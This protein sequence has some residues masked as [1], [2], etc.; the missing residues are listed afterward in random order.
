[1]LR[2]VHFIILLLLLVVTQSF[3]QEVT[4]VCNGEGTSKD[5]AVNNALRSAVEQTF[6][7]FVSSNTE[8]VNDELIRDEIV[9]I[10]RGNIKNF[11]EISY[12]D[13]GEQK[14][15]TLE[16]TVSVGQLVSYTKNK[17]MA[18]ELAGATF[19]TNFKLRKLYLENG[20]KAMPH[21]LNDLVSYAEKMY[22]F[23]IHTKEPI[24]RNDDVLVDITI[25][26]TLNKN[27][28]EFYKIYKET[29][30]KIENS[31]RSVRIDGS[32]GNDQ[33]WKIIKSYKDIMERLPR[34]A[35]H[36][37]DV[38]DNLNDTVTYEYVE[39]TL[40]LKTIGI[41]AIPTEARRLP[42]ECYNKAY[43]T[44]NPDIYND[45]CEVYN[46][47]GTLDKKLSYMSLDKRVPL[48]HLNEVNGTI[49]FTIVYTLD[50]IARINKIEV[51]PS[52]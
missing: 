10:S 47:V 52:Q 1:M 7:A 35:A 11:K 13:E 18:T 34:I 30:K 16:A 50:K 6:G 20:A 36:N 41:E 21:L 25:G 17:G 48:P 4:L 14:R 3:A 49:R 46:S 15:V 38:I 27:G 37:F 12:I 2:K 5:E 9:S 33:N 45:V 42:K 8:V 24:I 26:Y 32:F 29:I 23:T 22:D 28:V 44:W 19:A 51:V 39:N 40:R 31:I 43:G